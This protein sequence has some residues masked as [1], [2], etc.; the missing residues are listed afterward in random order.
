MSISLLFL[1]LYHWGG[2]Q[3]SKPVSVE[4]KAYKYLS[5]ALI[6]K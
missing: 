5:V 6:S 4:L 2:R 3:G 1:P